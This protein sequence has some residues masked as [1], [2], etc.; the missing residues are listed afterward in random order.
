M[1]IYYLSDDYL[2]PF[3]LVIGTHEFK[4]TRAGLD[5]LKEAIDKVEQI[6][7]ITQKGA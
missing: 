6:A 5:K 7:E 2:K 1:E 3:R 4:I